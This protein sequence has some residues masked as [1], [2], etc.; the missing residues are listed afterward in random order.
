MAKAK[1]GYMKCP[2][3]QCATRLV[4]KINDKE[5]LSCRCDECDFSLYVTKGQAGY[6]RWVGVIER[7]AAPPAEPKSAP[8]ASGKPAAEKKAKEAPAAPAAASSILGL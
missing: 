5:T 4:V 1:F 3:P 8:A 7:P 6:A 2:T